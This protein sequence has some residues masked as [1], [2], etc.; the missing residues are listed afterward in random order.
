MLEQ[1][2]G[3]EIFRDAL[4]SWETWGTGIKFF[5]IFVIAG[6]TL[7]TFKALLRALARFIQRK[8]R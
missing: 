6:L 3:A 1:Y 5:L 7:S 8:R 2:N 4:Y